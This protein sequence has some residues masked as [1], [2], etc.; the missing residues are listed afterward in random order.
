MV[1]YYEEMPGSSPGMTKREIRHTPP[2]SGYLLSSIEH[3]R[4][5]SQ[6]KKGKR[7]GAQRR[8][9]CLRTEQLPP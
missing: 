6:Y 7:P 9:F 2:L 5:N 8:A 4:I 3:A 1:N